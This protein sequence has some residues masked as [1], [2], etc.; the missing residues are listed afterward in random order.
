MRA[1]EPQLGATLEV[2]GDEGMQARID[3]GNEGTNLLEATADGLFVPE[4]VQ[5]ESVDV[6][7]VLVWDGSIWAAESAVPLATQ[8][9]DS[10]HADDADHAD[11]ADA[12]ARAENADHADD[13][14][15]A[16]Y[17]DGWSIGNYVADG[18][19]TIVGYIG[20]GDPSGPTTRYIACVT[21]SA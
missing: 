8:A 18:S 3:P 19:A 16:T 13:A 17:W 1:G 4:W 14:D 2:V 6:G 11:T 10:Y 21:P 15:G 12:A 7:D 9:E 5:T 20:V